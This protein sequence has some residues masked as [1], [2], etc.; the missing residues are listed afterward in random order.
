VS[1][2]P[3][4]AAA[5]IVA[6]LRPLGDPERAAQEK[7]YLKSELDFLGVPLPVIRRVVV[8]AAAAGP[9]QSDTAAA[10]PGQSGA[11]GEHRDLGRDEVI[12]WALALWHGGPPRPKAQANPRPK[13]QADQVLWEQRIAAVELLSARVRDLTADDLDTVDALIRAGAGWALVDPLAGDVVG[14]IALAHPEA[15]RRIDAWAVDDDFWIRRAALL[16]LLQGIRAGQPDL[17]RFDRYAEPMLDE[18]EFFI[19]KSIGWVLREIAK[20]DPGYVVAWTER[21]LATMSGV[22]FREAIRRLPPDD[23]HRLT[24]KRSAQGGSR[25][26][27]STRP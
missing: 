12:A 17:A 21:H 27:P 9:G 13:A 26:S 10:G 7:R 19:R 15:W 8:A 5:A 24:S 11:A 4:T 1:F 23:A 3:Q 2:N 18:K 14:K 16:S 22:T 20:K 6:A 25:R